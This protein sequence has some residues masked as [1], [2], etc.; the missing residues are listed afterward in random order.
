MIRSPALPARLW[1]LAG[2]SLAVAGCAS[3]GRSD[4][5]QVV[6]RSGADYVRIEPQEAEGAPPNDHPAR[7]T[8]AEVRTLLASIEVAERHWFFGFGGAE[9]EAEPLFL[10]AELERIAEP[11]ARALA[12]AGPR[13]DVT[14][15]VSGRRYDELTGLLGT[16]TTTTARVFRRDGRLNLI[17]G[18][19]LADRRAEIR[20]RDHPYAGYVSE[21][22]RLRNPPRPGARSARDGVDVALGSAAP[23]I[24]LA[25]ANGERRADWLTIEPE[26]ILTRARGSVPGE[27][28]EAVPSAPRR[29]GTASPAMDE[30]APA[31]AVEAR[32]RRLKDLY[33]QGLLSESLYE[34]LVREA[35]DDL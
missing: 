2:L 14:F 9:G 21:L 24:E 11:L 33:D 10:D 15:A 4:D 28:E 17:F 1:L 23:G 3:A 31:P 12:A 7:F 25:A 16:T 29:S 5:R 35:L 22:D 26:A 20:H 27:R 34:E 30:A 19:V 13:A 32:L 18:D 8:P 6:W